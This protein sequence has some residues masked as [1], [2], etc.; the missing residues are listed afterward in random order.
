MSN[1]PTRPDRPEM[2]DPNQRKHRPANTLFTVMLAAMMA[3]AG[4]A[5]LMVMP[6]VGYAPV[7]VLAVF[8]FAA[9]H[10]FTWGWWLSKSI[11]DKENKKQDE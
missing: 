3:V 9:L 2:A 4:L 8:G 6:L 1:L 5:S 10:Y 7:I 11:R